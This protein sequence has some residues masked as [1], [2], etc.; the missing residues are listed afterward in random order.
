MYKITNVTDKRNKRTAN[1]T[2]KTKTLHKR[3]RVTFGFINAVWS[4]LSHKSNVT[5]KKHH[6][7]QPAASTTKHQ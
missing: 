4:V 5:Y 6:N 1:V 2:Q 7:K 3:T